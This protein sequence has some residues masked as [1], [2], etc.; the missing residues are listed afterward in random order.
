M[1]RPGEETSFDLFQHIVCGFRGLL[2][3]MRFFIIRYTSIWCG[4]AAYRNI[5]FHYIARM[6]LAKEAGYS[7]IVFHHTAQIDFAQEVA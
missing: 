7:N 4:G 3:A 6:D 5:V 1:R 2:A